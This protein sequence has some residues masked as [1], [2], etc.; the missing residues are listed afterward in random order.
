MYFWIFSKM[1]IVFLD[2]PGNGK[3]ITGK[4]ISVKIHRH[5]NSKKYC[6]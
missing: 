5:S 6:C 3:W 1:L 4:R 2:D